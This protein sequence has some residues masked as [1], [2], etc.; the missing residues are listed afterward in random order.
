MPSLVAFSKDRPP[1]LELL[2][3]S[4]ARFAPDCPLTV[5][6]TASD[7]LYERGYELVRGR[8]PGV[9]WLDERA[10]GGFKAATLTAVRAAGERLAFLVDD[11]VLTHPVDPDAPGL[12]ALD[13]DPELLCCSLRLDPAKDYCYALDSAMRVP[14]FEDGLK[15]TWAAEEGDWCYPMSTDGHVFRTHQIVPLLETLDYFNPNSLEAA[16]SEAPLPLPK[17]TC[18]DQARLVNVPDNRVQDTALNR[19]EGG[20]PRR[21]TQALLA[22]RR[23]DLA[24][25][26][27]LRT[28]QVH[29]EMP[30]A[31]EP[32]EPKPAVSV[33]IP[34]HNMAATLAEAVESVRASNFDRPVEIIVVDDGST[35]ESAAIARGL[36]VTL[37]SQ[38]ASGH[39]ADARNGGFTAA[40]GDYVLPLDADDRIAPD[41]LAFTV[42]ALEAD[43]H[44]GFAYGDELDFGGAQ[45]V[46][47][48]TPAYDF[49]VLARQNFLGS[50]TL[51]R[52]SAWEA[53]GGY[54]AELGYEDWDL[55][56]ALGHAGFHGVK[57]DG[58]VFEHRVSDGRWAMD[59][60]R[61]REVKARFVLK[62]PELYDVAQRQWAAGVLE[63]DAVALAQP[64]RVGQIPAIVPAVAPAPPAR[65]EI[66]A[67]T[68]AVAATADEV[69]ADPGLLRAY[70]AAFGPDDD[71]TLV[72][73]ADAPADQIAARLEP[74]LAAAGLDRP[75][76]PDLLAVPGG[77]DAQA[78]IE[79]RAA[80]AL[81][82]RVGAFGGLPRFDD[83]SVGELRRALVGE[84]SFEVPDDMAWAFGPDGFYEQDVT[85]WFDRLV[86]MLEPRVV[87]DVGAN[88]GWFAVRAARAG[89]AVRAFEP[90][91]TTADVLERNLRGTT[92]TRVIRAAVGEA[93][94]TALMHL[95]S[96][97]GNNSLVERQLPPGHA[98]RHTGRHE[99]E[100]LRLDDLV[101]GDGFPAPE[102]VKID[103]E[104][105][106]L[107][108]LR[109]ARETLRRHRPA[110]LLE[111]S[112]TT[113][114]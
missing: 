38:P 77:S 33:V 48:K 111:W 2:L 98:L 42:A 39:P 27:G 35:D 64:D 26:D 22:G 7:E 65:I 100:I 21:L 81:T 46:F 68:H 40:S 75:D 66:D 41:F 110:L 92:D 58:A 51:V 17:M 16:L 73:Y 31:F 70:A 72:I 53:V 101:G 8:H 88:C 49:S 108:A 112:V 90:V 96:S 11:I 24:P 84:T 87:Y 109:G 83:G 80:A 25:F 15:W 71:V 10:E 13:E 74:A 36:G 6:Y 28:R 89:A 59:I 91:P 86:Q 105:Y 106:E 47:H 69:A 50:A 23:L 4:V 9:R 79:A 67:R 57:A 43:P 19:H 103:I 45:D 104:G 78:A 114:R 82:R 12:R 107:H 32:V 34:C 44:A 52:R 37:L 1:Q 56:I 3:R 94:G 30:L 60:A 29:Q 113:C 102:L 93:P 76:A 20:S 14:A 99:V 85:E 63:G 95:Y 18:L 62:R 54:D 55:W 5:I 61:D 97:C